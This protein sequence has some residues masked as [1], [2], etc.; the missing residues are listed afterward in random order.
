LFVV[1]FGVQMLA[2]TL[3]LPSVT[4]ADRGVALVAVPV[5]AHVLAL[6]VVSVWPPTSMP[7]LEDGVGL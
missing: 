7:R 1:P 6:L 2:Q 5:V 3:S 4:D